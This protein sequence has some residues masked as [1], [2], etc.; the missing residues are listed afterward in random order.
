MRSLSR[1]RNL[2]G[3]VYRKMDSEYTEGGLGRKNVSISLRFQR[4][5]TGNNLCSHWAPGNLLS[6]E[7]R[8]T[9]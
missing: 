4:M 3:F 5:I 1:G 7:E 2:V 8:K 9:S 6:T